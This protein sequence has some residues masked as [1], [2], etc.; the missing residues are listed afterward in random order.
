MTD[1]TGRESRIQSLVGDHRSVKKG[2]TEQY[3]MI[4]A[5]VEYIKSIA[6]KRTDT[7]KSQDW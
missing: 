1:S 7:I 2:Q 3:D 5:D 4:L 6:V